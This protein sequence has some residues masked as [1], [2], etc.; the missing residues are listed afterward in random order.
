M[1]DSSVLRFLQHDLA[2]A[3]AVASRE[4]SPLATLLEPGTQAVAVYRFGSWVLR[5]PSL[6]RLV[7]DPLYWA[8]NG[9]VMV[10]WGIEISRHARIG[11]GL[12]IGHFGGIT[13]SRHAV[14]GANCSLS[15]GV[16]IGAAG[17]GERF[18]APTIGD[19]CYIAPGAKLFGDIRVGNNVKVGANA[20]VH[21]D[22]PD[23]AVVALKPGF[24][25]I[26][27]RGNRR[28]PG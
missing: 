17:R 13:V 9:L 6:P 26:S 12:Y 19:D 14:I 1:V 10:L 28:S 24:T 23:N 22:V 20:V 8:L 5:M 15:Q 11:P 3:R 2:R 25:I 18:G 27:F 4:D 7:L 21:E 16:V